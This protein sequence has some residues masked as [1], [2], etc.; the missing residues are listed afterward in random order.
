MGFALN[1]RSDHPS[2][3]AIVE[4]W[5]EVSA[6]EDSASM[7][8]L[9]YAPHFTFAMYDSGAIDPETA[10]KALQR[11]SANETQQRI[12]FR[13]IR[14]FDGSPLVLWAEPE[15]AAGLARIHR[16]IH[17][18]IDPALCRPHYRPGAWVPHCTLGVGVR[19]DHRDQ[20]LGF[21]RSFNRSIEVVFDVVDCVAYPA[22]RIVSEQR[23]P[24]SA[25]QPQS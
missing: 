9:G 15:S 22:T 21:A 7:R 14:Y 19:D 11:A 18:R 6:F 2:A 4:L 25:G 3:Q 17:A 10:W 16:S 24:A 8:A 13:R 20:A 1:I 5:D 12:V 23:L